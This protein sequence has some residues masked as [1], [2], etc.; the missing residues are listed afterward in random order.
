[1]LFPLNPANVECVATKLGQDSLETLVVDRIQIV[2]FEDSQQRFVIGYDL[3]G[4]TSQID[5][6]LRNCPL[7]G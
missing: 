4:H 5:P 7:N 2:A 6:T 1:M 3:E